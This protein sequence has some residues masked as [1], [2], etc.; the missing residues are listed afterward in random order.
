M[1]FDYSTLVIGVSYIPLGILN[2]AQ[3]QQCKHVLDKYS[4]VCEVVSGL[5]PQEAGW[6]DRDFVYWKLIS[7]YLPVFA[8]G[9]Q[10]LKNVS[11]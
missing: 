5:T 11:P 9:R 2:S 4:T 3:L 8:L 1:S 6:L 7:A 10:S